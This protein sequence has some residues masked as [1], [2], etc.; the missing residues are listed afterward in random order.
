M[1]FG[2]VRRVKALE[3]RVLSPCQVAR[4]LVPEWLLADWRAQGLEFDISDN[5]SVLRA[6]GAVARVSIDSATGVCEL[7]ERPGRGPRCLSE[8]IPTIDYMSE[9]DLEL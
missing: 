3:Q 7:E 2:L 9:G 6:I 8:D 5:A 4:A 1:K